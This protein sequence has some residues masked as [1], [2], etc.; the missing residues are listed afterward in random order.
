MNEI[1]SMLTKFTAAV[2]ADAQEENNKILAELE[3]NRKSEM[4]KAEN[5]I[6]D[7][8]YHRIQSEIEKIHNHTNQVLSKQTLELK[9]SLIRKQEELRAK[10]HDECVDGL[11]AF[12]LTPH[13]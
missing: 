13:Y 10:L 12:F 11:C 9:K 5:E 2:F 3:A 7:E 8:A 6:L 1:D 4:D